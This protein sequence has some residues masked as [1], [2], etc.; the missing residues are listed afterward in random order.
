M[1][2]N[3]NVCSCCRSEFRFVAGILKAWGVYAVC[4]RSATSNGP[5]HHPLRRTPALLA[6]LGCKLE[7]VHACELPLHA[8][9]QSSE[10]GIMHD[11]SC[12]QQLL[13]PAVLHTCCSGR[14]RPARKLHAQR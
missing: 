9:P 1:E 14:R 7:T 4:W 10:H 13:L 3:V 8:W 2:V 12:P 11:L 6:L 5:D